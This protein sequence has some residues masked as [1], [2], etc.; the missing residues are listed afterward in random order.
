MQFCAFRD[1]FGGIGRTVGCIGLELPKYVPAFRH[2]T[3]P[4]SGVR[5][6]SRTERSLFGCTAA[7]GCSL[8]S[9][10]R[11]SGSVV[12]QAFSGCDWHVGNPIESGTG[13]PG[14]TPD[15]H[16]ES[17]VLT[18]LQ[19]LKPRSRAGCWVRPIFLAPHRCNRRP[20]GSDPCQF[21]PAAKSSRELASP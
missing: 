16:Y 14:Y 9:A 11:C 4:F 15:L 7:A 10:G 2:F 19:I 1:S 12:V 5:Q 17:A 8:R 18:A 3:A 21:G 6:L 20:G 13:I